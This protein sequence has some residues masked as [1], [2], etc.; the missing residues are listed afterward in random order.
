MGSLLNTKTGSVRK[1]IESRTV[2]SRGPWRRALAKL[3]LDTF[4][5]EAG[6]EYDASRFGG[7][8]DYMRRKKIKLQNLDAEIR[9]SSAGNPPIFRGVVAHVNGYTQPSLQD[10]HRL[11]VGH[12]GGFLQY[13]DGKTAATHVIASSL[14]PKKREEFRRYRV[15]QPAWV[16]ESVR[17]GRLLPWD[18][19]RVVDEGHAQKVLR[20][21]N[22]RVSSQI[23]TNPPS[24]YKTQSR[25]SWYASQLKSVDIEAGTPSTSQKTLENHDSNAGANLIPSDDIQSDYGDFPSF[26][27]LD[28]TQTDFPVIEEAYVP[29]QAVAEIEEYYSPPRIIQSEPI[30]VTKPDSSTSP[31]PL[32]REPASLKTGMSSEE[33]NAQLLSDPKTRNTSVGNPEF[34]QQ[35]YR[36]SRLHHLSTWKAELKAQLMSAAKEKSQTQTSRPKLGPGVRRYILHVDFDSFFAAVSI[37]K[38]PELEGKPVAIAHGTGSGSEIASCNYSARDFGLKNGMWMKSALQMCPGLKVLPYDFPAYEDASQKFYAAVLA[39]DGVVQSVSIDEALIDVTGQCLRAGGSDGRG[40]SEGSIYGEEA[41]ADEIAECL[42][43]SVKEKTGCDVSVGIGGNILL[44]KVALRRAKPAGQFQLKPDAVLDFIGELTVRDLPGVGHS[45]SAKLEEIGVK[46]VKDIRTLSKERL[47]SSLG[48]KT[49]AKMWDYARGIDQSEVGHEVVRKSVS[50]EVN[51]GIRFTN[52]IQA[53]DFVRSL[54]DEL[55]RRL[56]DN[57]VKGRQL[58]LKVMRRAPDAPLEPAKHLGHG[59]CDV[60][61]KS[62]MLGVA[63]NAQDVIGKE[64]VSMLKSFNLSSGDLRGLGVQMTKLEPLKPGPMESSQMQLQFNKSPARKKVEQNIDPDDVDSPRKGDRHG[65]SAAESSRLAPSLND[66]SHKP[67]NLSGTQF[68]MPTQADPEVLAE[69]PGD[70][71]SRLISQGKSRPDAV[72]PVSPTPLPRPRRQGTAAPAEF[73]PQSQLDPDTLA[74]LP[75]DV[76]AEILAYYDPQ[77][78]S[79]PMPLEPPHAPSAGSLRLKKPTTPTKRRRGRPSTK[80]LGNMKLT[81]SNFT[82]V[83]PRT[84]D[85]TTAEDAM[86][87]QSSSS[88][89]EVPTLDA[90]EVSTEFLAALPE[91]IRQEILAEQRRAQQQQRIANTRKAPAPPLP[92]QR[93]GPVLPPLPARPTFTAQKLTQLPDLRHAVDEWHSAFSTEGPF[94]EDVAALSKYLHRVIVEEKDIDKAV[95]VVNWTSWL[96]GRQQQPAEITPTPRSSNGSFSSSLDVVAWDRALASLQETVVSALE[97]RGLPP[98]DFD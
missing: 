54:C 18:S 62:V 95:S 12:G 96:I 47:T 80:A 66:S 76:R 48:P 3:V 22:G 67:L 84:S 5:D 19:F 81:Q 34:L 39:V 30:P 38:H 24:A 36:E 23:N 20:F 88:G 92:P 93:R 31:L 83:R 63:T 90:S 27:T 61:N 45:L 60:F 46:F 4:E 87:P 51:W 9:S 69:L 21:D 14:T 29:K 43:A 86:R 94:A 1:R 53:E 56:I 15:V 40:V 91:D 78:P 16:V 65:L 2:P 68:I 33:Y 58:T 28:A 97:E 75:D 72:R 49:G 10:L 98:V 11:I 77:Q 71:R 32:A 70:I 79:R 52:Q 25:S 73:P 44:A 7:F 55:H 57:L 17:A 8:G 59:K 74:A 26:N 35:Y 13:L 89:H 42:R 6:E 82:A 41:K 37:R 85:S 50:A 64:A